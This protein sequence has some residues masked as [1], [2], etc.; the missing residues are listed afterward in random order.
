M[1][2]LLG[3]VETWTKG[4]YVSSLLGWDAYSWQMLNHVSKEQVAPTFGTEQ[5]INFPDH[6]LM[7]ILMIIALWPMK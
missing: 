6:A 7:T 3:N 2:G 1:R 4:D 5:L